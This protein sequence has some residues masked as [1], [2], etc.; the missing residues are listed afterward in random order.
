MR[1]AP[2]GKGA[3]RPKSHGIVATHSAMIAPGGPTMN[4]FVPPTRADVARNARLLVE[5]WRAGGALQRYYMASQ[6]ASGVLVGACS[7]T[8]LAAGLAGFSAENVQLLGAATV[9]FAHTV[10]TW[11]ILKTRFRV[12]Y[13]IW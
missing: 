5:D 13:A 1:V 6:F 2:A 12:R 10:V 11:K 3:A 8:G 4:R 7:V 9:C